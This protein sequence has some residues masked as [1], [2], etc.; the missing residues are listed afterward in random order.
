MVWRNGKEEKRI[1][2]NGNW[3]RKEERRKGKCEPSDCED[4]L[5]SQTHL[6]D[7]FVPT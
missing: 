3:K 1:R 4:A 2:V 5:F 7:A 6:R